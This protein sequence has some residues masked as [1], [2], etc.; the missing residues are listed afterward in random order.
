MTRRRAQRSMIGASR[1][2][3]AGRAGRTRTV[4]EHRLII[5]IFEAEAEA[6]AAAHAIKETGAAIEDAIGVL[7][8]DEHG[9]LKTH[10]VGT[11]SAGKGA[12]IGAVLGL[13]GPIGLGLGAG[14]GAL[15][16]KLHHKNLGLDDADRERLGAALH[17]GKAAVGVLASPDELVA[18]ESILVGR[19]GETETH[20]LDAAI[21]REAAESA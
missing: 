21:V 1:R 3:A 5:S 16:G 15:L 2:R 10:K 14:G 19:G 20:E 6:D 17:G 9:K 8:L 13:L 7:V 12:A 18:I 11:T 4:S